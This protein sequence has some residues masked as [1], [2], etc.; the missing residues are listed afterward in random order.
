MTHD[1]HSSERG[2]AVFPLFLLVLFASILSVGTVAFTSISHTNPLHPTFLERSS[3]QMVWIDE[4]VGLGT[5]PTSVSLSISDDGAGLDEVIVR[6]VQNNQ[7]QELQR[8]SFDEPGVS[9][10]RIDLTIDPKKL[11]LREGKVELQVLAFDKSLW[12]NRMKVPKSLVVNFSK[13]RID[14]VTPQQNGVLGGSELVFYKVLGKRPSVTGVSSNSSL[15]PGVPARLWDPSFDSHKDLYLSFFPIPK[16]FEEARDSMAI[17]A[18]DEVGNS[19]SAPFHYKV[20]PRSWSSYKI[21]LSYKEAQE[22]LGNLVT[23]AQAAGVRLKLTGEVPTDLSAAL[24]T[25]AR[26]D[27]SILSDA[28]SSEAKERLWSGAFSRPVGSYPTNSSGDLRSIVVEDKEILKGASSGVRFPVP[29]R[30]SVAAANGGVVAFVGELGLLGKT[31]VLD[32]GLGL[33][34]V[35]AHLSEASVKERTR[36]KQGQ[37]LG[38]TGRSGF[39]TSEGVYFETR[40][41]G[42]PVSPNEW[43]D[44]TWVKDH[45]EAKVAFVQR[46]LIGAPEAQR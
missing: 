22:A 24:K 34:T 17:S 28:L 12:S 13:P 10:I 29:A 35:Y 20:R 2:G 37:S 41:H 45:I 21:K 38:R 32:H 36:L 39:A 16:N 15:Y 6:L 27:E 26:L 3:P 5:D 23:H 33:T 9:D 46:I 7:P 30:T 14:V 25:V 8:T 31:V 40:V 44:E 42:V 11:E 1:I 4:P 18:R 19:S 43:W